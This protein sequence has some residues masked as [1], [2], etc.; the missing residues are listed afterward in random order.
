MSD[1]LKQM[2]NSITAL[3]N[4]PVTTLILGAI[5]G[6]GLSV[7]KD[8]IA[9]RREE[10]RR[11]RQELLTA[12]RELNK[13]VEKLGQ[14]SIQYFGTAMKS[15][16]SGKVEQMNP[17]AFPESIADIEFQV[18]IYAPELKPDFDMIYKHYRQ[19]ATNWYDG[20]M[21]IVKGKQPLD[22]ARKAAEETSVIKELMAAFGVKLLDFT[23]KKCG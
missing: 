8:A 6:F 3:F 11:Q 13:Q 23:K 1:V 16:L 4:N 7:W 15:L 21:T 9:F 17:S 20:N 2:L 19:L 18:A 22:E 5:L 14:S 10:K 12:L